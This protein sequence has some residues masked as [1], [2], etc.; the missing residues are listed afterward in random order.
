MSRLLFSSAAVLAVIA[1]APALAEPAP[2]SSGAPGATSEVVVTASLSGDSQRTDTIGS[3]ITVVQPID[4]QLRQVQLV[5]DVLRD[6]PGVE[7]SRTGTVGGPTQVRMRGAEGN[8]T[9]VLIDGIKVSDPYQG[10]FDFATLIADD[11]AKVEVL[12]GQQSALYGSDAIGG[13]I[14]YITATG[15]EA[16]GVRGHVE[17][18]SFGTAQGS[19][20]VAGV[21]GPLDY[22]ISG[23][24]YRTDGTPTA[25]MGTRDVGADIG[26]LSAKFILSPNDALHLKAVGRYSYTRADA[27]DSETDPASPIF[28]Y[29]VD[30]PGVYSTDKALYGLVG[31]E[32]VSLGGKWTNAV[33]L[34]GVE[35]RRNSFEPFGL[36]FGDKG[37]RIKGSA[38]STLRLETGALDHTLTAAV[39]AEKEYFQTVD[40]SGFADTHWHDATDIGFVGEYD[41]RLG[42]R[43]GLGAAVRYDDDNRFHNAATYHVQGSYRL[44]SGTRLHAAAGSGIKNPGFFDLYGYQDGRY[45]GNPNLKPERSNG[46]EAGVDQTLLEGRLAAGVTYFHSRLKDQIVTTFPPPNF[47]S[48][49]GNQTSDATQQGVETSLTLRMGAWRINGAY[50]WLK[51]QEDG[52]QDVRRAPNIASVNVSWRAPDDRFGADLTVRHNGE[53]KDVTFTDPTFATE[54]IVTLPAFTLVN[55]GA[56][57]RLTRKLQLYGRIE[58]LFDARYEEVFSFREPGRAAYV[59]LRAGF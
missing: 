22:A 11:V 54:P 17:G 15:A 51:A 7:V 13:V 5:S 46:W 48:T 41:L 47:V 36:S 39:D 16:P 58:N 50:T 38:V 18:G 30:S 12:R 2:P 31:A 53:Q 14:H 37:A 52:A 4:L 1:A 42:E 40:P 49:P 23:S 28:G 8:H 34:Q 27:N 6:V 33:N 56:D 26:V 57:Y 19:G 29:T 45:I 9:L 43:L 25:R 21:S 59:G 32:L 24:Y 35:A 20:R 55:L 10:E 44:D 3:S